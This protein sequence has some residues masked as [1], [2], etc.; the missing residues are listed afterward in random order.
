MTHTREGG[1]FEFFESAINGTYNITDDLRVGAQVYMYEYGRTGNWVPVLDWAFIDWRWKDWLGFRLGKYKMRSGLYS[2]TQDVPFVNQWILVP[3]GNYPRTQRTLTVSAW[4]L[5]MYGDFS[6]GELGDISYEVYAGR[7]YHDNE[8]GLS[9]TLR[10]TGLDLRSLNRT[11]SGGGDIRWHTPIEGLMIGGS[12][13]Y[14]NSDVTGVSKST[15][16]IPPGL[17]SYGQRGWS[18]FDM[19]MLL[20]AY[21]KYEWKKW[22]FFVD[23]DT[24]HQK[25]RTRQNLYIIG[26]PN[27]PT[28]PFDRSLKRIS[29]A[30]TFGAI[31]ELHDKVSLG[32]YVCS[33]L[34]DTQTPH[35]IRTNYSNDFCFSVRY[36]I[37]NNLILKGE[38]HY[39]NGAGFP[40]A[41][42]TIN[43]NYSKNWGLFA[44]SLSYNF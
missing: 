5:N 37:T 43:T 38:A 32:G 44:F 4:G 30:I 19:I 24:F 40:G 33:Y 31:Y 34:A 25:W 13:F 11:F 36:N 1:S 10:R 6:I 3:Q 2:D 28:A 14:A 27:I 29:H 20:R 8:S 9:E 16:V 12:L 42:S 7:H 41:F 26:P 35:K 18:D 23:Y 21:A 39:I 17:G 15:A 22:T